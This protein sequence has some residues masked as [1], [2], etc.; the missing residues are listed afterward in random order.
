LSRLHS[1][2]INS[3]SNATEHFTCAV[4]V[5]STRLFHLR[6]KDAM[7]VSG[8]QGE[9]LQCSQVEYSEDACTLLYAGKQVEQRIALIILLCHRSDSFMKSIVLLSVSLIIATCTSSLVLKIPQK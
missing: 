4:G 7:F 8:L 9:V 5:I 3:I 2:V 1:F 6:L